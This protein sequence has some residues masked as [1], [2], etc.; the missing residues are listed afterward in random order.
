M[1]NTP[2][3]SNKMLDIEQLRVE[4]F[5]PGFPPPGYLVS[6]ACDLTAMKHRVNV[7]RVVSEK[8]VTE[9]TNTFPNP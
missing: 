4:T 5:Q 6:F 3:F 1:V 7:T 9:S 2:D 8:P